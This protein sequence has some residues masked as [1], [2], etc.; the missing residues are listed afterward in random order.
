[1]HPQTGALLALEL[2][3]TLADRPLDGVGE[4][5]AQGVVEQVDLIGLQPPGHGVGRQLG[6]VQ[7]LVA[8]RVADAR[9]PRLV[10]D[11]RFDALGVP[12][13]QLGE[14][15][16]GDGQRIWPQ[17]R[18]ARHLRRVG[19]EVDGQALLGARLGEVEAGAADLV[20]VQP[21]LQRALAGLRRHHRSGVV[22]AQ[23]ARP[24]QVGDQVERIL[25]PVEELDGEE[26]PVAR[27]PGDDPPDEG[28]HRRVE[29]L[30]GAHRR[31]VDPR[32]RA[33]EGVLAQVVRE[34][35]DLGQ[36]GH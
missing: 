15:R 4:H 24:G 25:R 17:A 14:L 27:R 13:E 5:R 3:G 9:E 6:G 10:D 16:A 21:E 32:D 1:V 7:D 31:D 18:D 26:L 36:L 23:P 22:P 34:R 28:L 20:E 35:L 2:R 11:Q 33:V 30:D 8:V 12:G 29:G 19:D